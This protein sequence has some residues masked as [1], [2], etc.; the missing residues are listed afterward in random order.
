MSNGGVPRSFPPHPTGDGIIHAPA[1]LPLADIMDRP[2]SVPL[3]RLLVEMPSLV[4]IDRVDRA[5]VF[6]PRRHGDLETGLV[7]LSLLGDDGAGE[8]P[9][10]VVT[11]RYEHRAAAGKNA[12]E[13]R[14]RA[15]HGWAPAER[16]PRVIDGVLRRLGEAGEDP[17]VVDVAGDAA[18]WER[19]A[20]EAAGLL[21]PANGE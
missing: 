14:T 6:P 10:E 1:R 13:A 3:G 16:V 4:P 19:F 7:V 9:R 2:V 17:E 18:R 5:W 8:A 12:E 20:G 15:S 21:D 11:V